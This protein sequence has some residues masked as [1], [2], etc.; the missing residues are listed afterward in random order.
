MPGQPPEILRSLICALDIVFFLLFLPAAYVPFLWTS[1]TYKTGK[2]TRRDVWIA[3]AVFL[4]T[5][6]RTAGLILSIVNLVR[7]YHRHTLCLRIILGLVV[8]PIDVRIIR[9]AYTTCRWASTAQKTEETG[10]QQ[11]FSYAEPASYV[12]RSQQVLAIIDPSSNP[13]Y[14]KVT[15]CYT[16]SHMAWWFFPQNIIACGIVFTSI[17]LSKTHHDGDWDWAAI[18]IWTT[19]LIC[20]ITDQIQRYKYNRQQRSE[21]TENIPNTPRA[22][23]TRNV[24]KHLGFWKAWTLGTMVGAFI[25][26]VLFATN[27]N[28]RKE[29]ITD[30]TEVWIQLAEALAGCG[31]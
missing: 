14:S 9:W 12:P 3:R 6:F 28:S 5:V 13:P 24:S 30:M 2:I 23:G 19:P 20:V 17:S 16:F 29:H 15:L 25:F 11:P 8:G 18:M 27:L 10:P 31:G 4:V 1:W 21:D 26:V 22:A 7:D